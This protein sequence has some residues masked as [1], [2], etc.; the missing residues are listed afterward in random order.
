MKKKIIAIALMAIIC[1][2][3]LS[4]CTGVIETSSAG[5]TRQDAASQ[6]KVADVL[7]TNP[8][9]PTDI[10]YS[11]E[12]YNL[13]RRAYWVNGHREK[14]NTL[15][16]PIEKPLGYIVLFAG[17]AIVGRF[18]VDGKVSSLNSFLTPS[19][20]DSVYGNS[21]G[22]YTTIT[23]ETADV[24]G[25]YGSNDKGIF[26]FTPEGNYLEWTGKYLYTDI[27]VE[28]KDPVVKYEVE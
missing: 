5:G 25:S 17:E 1:L 14:A 3:L 18:V 8:K 27:P 23:T 12:R 21:S 20:I 28:V 2:V 10:D 7:A 16:C 19:N 9:T 11:L 26:F 24:D 22:G 6:A 15:I 13:I 4:G